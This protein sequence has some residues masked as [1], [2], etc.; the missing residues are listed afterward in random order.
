MEF[1]GDKN[2]ELADTKT[3][4]GPP[5]NTDDN[6]KVLKWIWVSLNLILVLYGIA[7]FIYGKYFRKKESLY[8]KHITEDRASYIENMAR[9]NRTSYLN[10]SSAFLDGINQD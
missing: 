7:L 1:Y 4:S 8:I 5:T 3:T 2:I 6:M 10:K 9:I